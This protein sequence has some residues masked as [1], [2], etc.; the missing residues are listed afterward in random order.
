M[1][2]K[3]YNKSRNEQRRMHF[4]QHRRNPPSHHIHFKKN[5]YII[6]YPIF[7]VPLRYDLTPSEK[8]LTLH[9]KSICAP[10]ELITACSQHPNF[11]IL[12]RSPHPRLV[13]SSTLAANPRTP[14]PCHLVFSLKTRRKK[15]EEKKMKLATSL[16]RQGEIL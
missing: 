11:S 15:D 9:R 3:Y 4:R 10:Y 6:K 12:C 14:Y 7:M 8:M 5:I 2:I 1:T 16:R 13:A